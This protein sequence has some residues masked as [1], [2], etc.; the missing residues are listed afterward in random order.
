M[1]WPIAI[2]QPFEYWIP[3]CPVFKYFQYL[4]VGYSDFHCIFNHSVRPG[5][6]VIFENYVHSIPDK[7]VYLSNTGQTKC[8]RSIYKNRG[9]PGLF[10]VNFLCPKM[11]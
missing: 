3:K 1:V 5:L 11:S 10:L 6:P 9:N 2:A 4:N 7:F 8:H